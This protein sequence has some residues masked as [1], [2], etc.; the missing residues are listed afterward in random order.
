MIDI[1]PYS[2][3][4]SRICRSLAVNR[5]EVVGSA[6]RDDFQPERSDID[7]VVDFEGAERL[8]ERYFDLKQQLESCFKRNVDIIQMKALKNPYV[9][10]TIEADRI[11]VYES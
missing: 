5:L 2:K 11:T 6:A 9:K 1:Q 10:S 4:I 8:F 7:V 3:T